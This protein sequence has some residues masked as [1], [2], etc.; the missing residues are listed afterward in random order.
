RT[1][2]GGPATRRPVW[3]ARGVWRHAATRTSRTQGRGARGR[4]RRGAGAVRRAGRPDPAVLC[5]QSGGV[6]HGRQGAGRRRTRGGA[7][8][9]VG[10]AGRRGTGTPVAAGRGPGRGRLP[11]HPARTPVT[12]IVFRPW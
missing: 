9:A 11:G 8:G 3:V 10:R 12:R 5:G 7:R 1:G 4:G 2:S 6:G